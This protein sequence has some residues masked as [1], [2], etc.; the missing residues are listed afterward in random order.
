MHFAI[1]IIVFYTDQA[2][3]LSAVC[4]Y[5][6]SLFPSVAVASV[7]VRVSVR[8]PG[9]DCGPILLPTVQSSK[10]VCG[11]QRSSPVLGH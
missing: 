10:G 9:Q 5:V 3:D 6:M 2:Q 4:K 8:E 11:P 7:S 1:T